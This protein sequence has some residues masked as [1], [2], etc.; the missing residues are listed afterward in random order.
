M[1][2]DLRAGRPLAHAD[3]EPPTP[4]EWREAVLSI[5]EEDDA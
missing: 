2:A 3:I 4:E 1:T 5:F